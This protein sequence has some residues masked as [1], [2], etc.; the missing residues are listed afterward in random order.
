MNNYTKEKQLPKFDCYDI[1]AKLGMMYKYII[2][3]SN[4]LLSRK[5]DKLLAANLIK[6]SKTI[7]KQT[8]ACKIILNNFALQTGQIIALL[9]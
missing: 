2:K 8:F 4:L 7:I 6:S 1:S 9:T 5:R 3:F